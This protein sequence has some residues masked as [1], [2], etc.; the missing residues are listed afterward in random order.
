MQGV[1]VKTRWLVGVLSAVTRRQLYTKLCQHLTNTQTSL[2]T[3]VGPTRCRCCRALSIKIWSLLVQ[4]RWD[5][6]N[7]KCLL[8]VFC[9]CFE[10]KCATNASFNIV[11]AVTA[12]L[13]ITC[14]FIAC[15]LRPYT[16]RFSVQTSAIKVST[17]VV[18]LMNSNRV[19]NF[20]LYNFSSSV[21]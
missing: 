13:T 15:L 2:V 14:L 11:M 7:V 17:L 5:T 8:L 19:S 10:R 20:A 21:R 1:P 12:V 3:L 16:R 18:V 4:I 9:M 6:Q